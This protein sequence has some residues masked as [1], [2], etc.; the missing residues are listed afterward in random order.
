MLMQKKIYMYLVKSND[1][2][3]QHGVYSIQ[4]TYLYIASYLDDLE[5]DTILVL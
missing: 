4:Y 2:F 1:A 3:L 5:S